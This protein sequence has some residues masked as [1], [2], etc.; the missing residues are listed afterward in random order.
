MLASGDTTGHSHRI[1]DRRT[2]QMFLMGRGHLAVFF[3]EVTA[4][5]AKVEHPEH[6]PI[7][8]PRGMYRVWRQREFGESGRTDSWRTE[9]LSADQGDGRG[10][11]QAPEMDF[12]T[13]LARL[14][15]GRQRPAWGGGRPGTRPPRRDRH[16]GFGP[17]DPMEM[18]SLCTEG[19][20]GQDAGQGDPH[21]S[22][23]K[24]PGPPT[25][26][27]KIATARIRR[28]GSSGITTG[29]N[30]RLFSCPAGPPA[31]SWCDTP[32]P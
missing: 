12:R 20:A 8:L 1:K 26:F 11:S 32:F 18:V 15:W 7:V 27:Q 5:E 23:A 10:N 25:S 16:P 9:A 30:W 17:F 22:F 14:G 29:K 28:P 3:L 6:G 21:G 19:I 31:E 2:A 13:E 24:L 4:E